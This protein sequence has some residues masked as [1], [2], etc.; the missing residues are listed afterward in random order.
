M[1]ALQRAAHLELYQHMFR[2]PDTGGTRRIRRFLLGLF[3]G[4]DY[5]F[6]LTSL[7]GLDSNLFES[8]LVVLASERGEPQIQYRME[9]CGAVSAAM[10]HDE[11]AA[12]R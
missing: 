11:V 12:I 10:F 2:H 9:E 5:P 6:D 8:C 1:T 3:D 7:S 4:D